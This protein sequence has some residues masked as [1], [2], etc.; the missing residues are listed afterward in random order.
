MTTADPKAMS[1]ERLRDIRHR[2]DNARRSHPAGRL[3]A[4]GDLRALQECVIE[5]DR[6]RAQARKDEAALRDIYGE[7]EDLRLERGYHARIGRVAE[8]IEVRLAARIP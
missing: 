6:L 5:I 4:M 2:L 1:D 7:V 3:P 8:L